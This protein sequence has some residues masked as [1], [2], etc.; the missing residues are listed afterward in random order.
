MTFFAKKRNMAENDQV[1]V[2][3]GGY[4]KI[5]SESV[6]RIY[7]VEKL[8]WGTFDGAIFGASFLLLSLP[9]DIF[10]KENQR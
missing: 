10:T 7:F 3:L 6:V 8:L 2:H 1:L 4:I 9:S 5:F